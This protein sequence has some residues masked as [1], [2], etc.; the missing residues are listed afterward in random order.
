MKEKDRLVVR[1]QPRLAVAEHAG[2]LRLQPIARGDDVLDLVADMMHPAAG[3]LLEIALGEDSLAPFMPSAA[4]DGALYA[5]ARGESG[6]SVQTRTTYTSFTGRFT[7][8]CPD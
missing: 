3:V 5:Q 2:A 1:A 4:I 8:R 6:R 7:C